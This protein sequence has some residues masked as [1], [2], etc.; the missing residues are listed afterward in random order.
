MLT[1]LMKDEPISCA[2]ILGK[3]NYKK[4]AGPWFGYLAEG[5]TRAL[6]RKPGIRM[7]FKTYFDFV[8]ICVRMAWSKKIN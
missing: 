3:R 1:E 7:I 2:D 5:L 6:G 8:L 4:I